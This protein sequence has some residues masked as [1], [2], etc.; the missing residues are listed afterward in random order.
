MGV[1]SPILCCE[2]NICNCMLLVCIH[3]YSV[4][5][6]TSTAVRRWCAFTH[7][8]MK[9]TVYSLPY[10]VK[11]GTMSVCNRVSVRVRCLCK[12]FHV[13]LQQT[14]RKKKRRRNG[15]GR[16][17]SYGIQPPSFSCSCSLCQ[18]HIHTHRLA[19]T[20]LLSNGMGQWLRTWAYKHLQLVTHW[21][22]KKT[23]P[24]PPNNKTESCPPLTQPLSRLL[25]LHYYR[26]TGHSFLFVCLD[27]GGWGGVSSYIFHL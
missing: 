24:P 15:Y 5:K 25:D 22:A 18:L 4:V 13:G 9:A 11:P 19:C 27:G 8:F 2:G 21:K 10:A 12:H 7:T 6:A 20:H 16:Q 14:E 26:C 17:M 23:L 3:P 1:H